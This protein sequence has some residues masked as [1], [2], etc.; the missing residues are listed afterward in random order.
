MPSGSGFD[1]TV[2]VQTVPDVAET[3]ELLDLA[4]ATPLILGVVGFV[5]LQAPDVGEELDRLRSRP[6][7]GWLVGIRSPVQDEPDPR[8]L[9]RPEVLSGLRAVAERG[10]V[11]DLLIR[12][13][14]LG[15]ALR[16]V[17]SVPDGRFVIDHLAKPAIASG[18]S[19]HVDRRHG[20]P[21]PARER[22]GQALGSG[23]GG[24]LGS[25]GPLMTC[26]PTPTTRS[27]ASEATECSSAPTGRCA[28]SRRPTPRWSEAAEALTGPLN[29][30]ERDAVMGDTAVITY[31][32][33]VG[34]TGSTG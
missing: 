24:Q 2:V 6:G 21:R 4:A 5:D 14:H 25:R 13:R 22:G 12:P 31:G 16:A 15:A 33:R 1:A 30:T 20:R 18:G 29:P 3:E 27:P 28:A 32:L 11:Y 8:W 9:L 34:A 10:L 26:G 17:T 7:G 23:H 19:E